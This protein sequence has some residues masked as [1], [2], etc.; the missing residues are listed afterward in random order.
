MINRLSLL[1]RFSILSLVITA[2][3]FLFVAWGL[4]RRQ[5]DNFLH[6]EATSAADQV[7]GILTTNMDFSDFIKPLDKGRYAQVDELIQKSIVDEHVV[8]VKLWDTQGRLIYTNGGDRNIVGQTTLDPGRLAQALSGKLS[9]ETSSGAIAGLRVNSSAAVLEIYA[10]VRLDG[11]DRVVGVMG[12]YHDLNVLQP[13]IS[14]MRLFVLI[15]MGLGAGF[16]YLSLFGI[17]RGASRQLVRGNRENQELDEKEQTRRAE[18]SALY[19]LSRNLAKSPPEQDRVLDIIVHNA[20][21]TIHVTFACIF[22]REEDVIVERAAHPVRVLDHEL[23]VG[24]CFMR[25]LCPFLTR[26]IEGSEPVVARSCE[27]TDLSSQERDILML[28]LVQTFCLVPI[29][30]GDDSLGAILLGE[31]RGEAREPF[32]PEKLRLC[33]SIADQT[34]SAIERARLFANLEESYLQ[35]VLSLANAVEA[36]DTYTKNHAEQVSNTAVRI[37]QELGLGFEEMEDL[38][39]GSILHDVG[40]IGIP[41]AILQKH[42]RLNEEEWQKMRT[43][44]TIGEDILKPV[45]RLAGAAKLVRHNHEH[46]DGTGY[47]DGLAGEDIPLAARILTVVDTYSAIVDRRPYKDARTRE[48]ALQELK[49][50]AGTQLDPRIVDIFIDLSEKGVINPA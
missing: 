6:M 34:A 17:M 45:P 23:H 29:R 35:T 20:V 48:E 22:L 3:V 44:V 50:S 38:R 36:K 5:E 12:V 26:A 1:T 27:L 11:S 4:E 25:D 10:P 21:D 7:K 42:G 40:K 16:L 13:A 31:A 15:S 9:T 41:D 43:H 28:D 18:L 14:G 49:R 19:E 32:S 33:V 39:Y 37:G 30:T 8:G 47:P 46:Y 24:L 2:G